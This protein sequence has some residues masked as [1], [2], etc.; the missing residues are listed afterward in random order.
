MYLY[1]LK[2]FQESRTLQKTQF[3]SREETVMIRRMVQRNV[4]MLLTNEHS[5]KKM[6]KSLTKD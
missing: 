2:H 4:K 5:V 1:D 6:L 3:V